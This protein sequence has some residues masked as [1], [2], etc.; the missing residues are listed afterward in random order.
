MTTSALATDIYAAPKSHHLT[1]R[2]HNTT[3]PPSAAGPRENR[4]PELLVQTRGLVASSIGWRF[5]RRLTGH[6]LFRTPSH[7]M[8]RTLRR[9][10]WRAL[11]QPR[12]DQP[13][14]PYIVLMT[15]QGMDKGFATKH[16]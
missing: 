10:V 13:S 7:E 5:K 16:E 3:H 12:T 2:R 9:R 4:F 8:R 15:C 6:A 1:V 14:R 11:C